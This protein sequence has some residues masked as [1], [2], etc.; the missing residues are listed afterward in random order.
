MDSTVTIVG[1]GLSGLL[2]AYRLSQHDI[3]FKLLEANTRFGGR[4]LSAV[5]ATVTDESYDANQSAVDLGPSWFWPGQNYLA[6]LVQEL[7]LKESVYLQQSAGDS[8]MEYG[9][10]A[11]VSGNASASMEGAYRLNGGMYHLIHKL[12]DALPAQ[13][14]ITQAQVTRIQKNE[15]GSVV[16][17]EL[18][19]H[20]QPI[21]SREVV[22]ALPPRVVARSIEFEPS[23]VSD[24]VQSLLAVPTW[25]AGQAKFV[26]VY[27]APFWRDKGLSGDALSQLGPLVEIHDASAQQGSPCALFGFVGIPALQRLGRD[28]PLKAVAIEQLV[29]LF[30]EPAGHPLS[31]HFKDWAFDELTAIDLDREGPRAHASPDSQ[32]MTLPGHNIVWAGSESSQS[33]NH[34]NGYLE[35]AVNAGERAAAVL[36]KRLGVPDVVVENSPNPY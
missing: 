7:G 29:R 22:L 24:S 13:S 31:V 35:G 4:I 26:A 8:V 32:W 3:A 2:V 21:V 18:P 17:A 15:V 20:T 33:F 19:D 12:L 10:G 27:D 36:L 14:L 5:T 16:I 34:S 25:M 28:E 30:G 6:N 23:L 11:I 1:G 9:D